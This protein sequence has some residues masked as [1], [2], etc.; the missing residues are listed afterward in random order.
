MQAK[1]ALNKAYRPSERLAQAQHSAVHVYRWDTGQLFLV[2]PYVGNSDMSYQEEFRFNAH[3]LLIELDASTTKMMML[4]SA[5]E[6]A[7]DYW[8]EATQRHDKAFQA[9][10]A[11][12][13]SDVSIHSS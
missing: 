5:K 8:N 4:V 6:V 10:H 1:E 11:F 9:W 7:G 2:R 3:E 13:A 12:L